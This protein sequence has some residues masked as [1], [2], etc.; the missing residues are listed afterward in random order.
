MSPRPQKVAGCD[1]VRQNRQAQQQ[2]PGGSLP[3]FFDR[4]KEYDLRF[5][6]KMPQGLFQL[7][8]QPVPKRTVFRMFASALSIF[9]LVVRP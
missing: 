5:Q 8:L 6:K 7:G 3:G 2:S 9:P 4:R 1:P